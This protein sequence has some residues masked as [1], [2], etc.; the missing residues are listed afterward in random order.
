MSRPAWYPTPAFRDWSIARGD[1]AST[2]AAASAAPLRSL[3][4]AYTLRRLPVPVSVR[5][6]L[7]TKQK[8]PA[9]ASL[10]IDPMFRTG[11][12]QIE[13]RQ[14]SYCRT[15]SP[16]CPVSLD[17]D[18]KQEDPGSA[19][20]LSSDDKKARWGPSPTVP[21]PKESLSR[22]F[23]LRDCSGRGVVGDQRHRTRGHGAKGGNSKKNTHPEAGLLI[24]H[25]SS[26]RLLAGV[27]PHPN[28]VS[29]PSPIWRA[30]AC[31]LQPDQASR[32]DDGFSMG[33]MLFCCAFAWTAT[34]ES[35][36]SEQ[37]ACMVAATQ[38]A[39]TS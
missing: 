3:A 17:T 20:E 9:I 30:V 26:A 29:P 38:H 8:K 19:R 13:H 2:G 18:E 24:A 22:K 7:R 6:S 23:T 15:S 39:N 33:L 5:P 16:I 14:Q 34:Y 12:R 31:D 37:V 28:S 32:E 25:Q 21:M 35:T 11:C 4:S 36:A 27:K 1:G 10:S